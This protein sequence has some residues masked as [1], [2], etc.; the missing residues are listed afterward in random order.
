MS[1]LSEYF[2]DKEK[3][4]Q[5]ESQVVTLQK[6]AVTNRNDKYKYK[7]RVDKFISDGSI[8]KNSLRIEK[9]KLLVSLI[10]SNVIELTV[11][12]VSDICFIGSSSVYKLMRA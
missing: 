5:L 8:S 12:Q 6:N 1:D 2:S 4:K 11:N 7:L 10:K 3:I 9:A